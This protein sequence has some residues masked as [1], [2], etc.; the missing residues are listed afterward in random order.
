MSSLN[1]LRI[2]KSKPDNKIIAQAAEILNRGG[3]VVVPTETRYGMLGRID[4]IKVLKK[5]YEMKKRSLDLPSAIFVHNRDEIFEFGC[6]CSLAATLAKQFMPGP[7]TIVLRDKSGLPKPIVVDGKIGLRYSSSPV[8]AKLLKK[9]EFNMTA[10]SANISGGG[11]LE[12]IEQIATVFQDRVDLYLDAGQLN[13]L[14]ST[15]VD[16]S[17]EKYKILRS[18]TFTREE[19]KKKIVKL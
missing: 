6:E 7:L 2:S 19:I 8:I 17:S 3:V 16:C 18:G 9:T 10:T 11:N 12:T 14:P 5:I 4:D 1:I 13:A 15:V